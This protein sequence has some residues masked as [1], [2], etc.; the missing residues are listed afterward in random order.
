MKK[1]VKLFTTIASLCL[2]VALMAFGV[3]AA[4]NV[5]FGVT[6]E[7]SFTATANV[8]AKVWHTT[9]TSEGCSKEGALADT[10]EETPDF[11]LLGSETQGTSGFTATTIALGTVKLTLH[12]VNVANGSMTY[13][14]TIN[15]KNTAP[16]NDSNPDLKVTVTPKNVEK[17]DSAGYGIATTYDG[18]ASTATT[19]LASGKS[20]SYTVTIT[21][22][23]AHTIKD[24]DLGTSV[25][26]E[27]LKN[28]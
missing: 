27:A 8:K 24:I 5:T 16:A 1:K 28:A 11:E 21:V 18:E 3:Y 6:N 17:V 7:V 15:I 25:A 22:D 20:M 10:T 14:Y 13:S 9:A 23:N 12:N 4:T 26:L 19:I 2:A